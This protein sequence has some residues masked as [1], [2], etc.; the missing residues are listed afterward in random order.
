MTNTARI[1]ETEA[2]RASYIVGARRGGETVR[3]R[4]SEAQIRAVVDKLADLIEVVHEADPDD[5]SE[6]F[7]R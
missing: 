3:P 1:A 4:M 6:I 2:E 7:R 5:R